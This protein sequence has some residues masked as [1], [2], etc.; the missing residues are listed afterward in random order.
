MPFASY[1]RFALASTDNTRVL[2][3]GFIM[4]FASSVGQTYFIGVFGPAIQDE[5]GLSHTA[6]GSIYMAGT[7]LS[8]LLLPWTGQQ[9]DRITLRRYTM[10]VC[11][12]L[13]AAAAF[14][15]LVPSAVFLIVAILLLRQAGQGLAIHTGTTAVAR[16][17][18]ADRG[19]AIAFATLG[20]SAGGSLLPFLAVLT[21]AAVGWRITFAA[22]AAVL[23]LVVTPLAWWL[24]GRRQEDLSPHETS[25][26]E[27][28]TVRASES[29]WTRAQVLRDWRFYFVVP[30]MVAPSIIVT[31]LFFHHPELARAKEWGIDWVAGSYWIYAAGSVAASLTA[32]PLIDR[33][34]A[35]QILPGSLI[36]M[37][38]ALFIVWAFDH[39]LWA[40][41]YLLL[42]GLTVGVNFT[43]LTSLWAEVYGVRHFGAIRSLATSISVFSSALGPLAMG[44]P[45]DAGVSVGNICALMALYC[46]AATVSL[47]I[48]LR[49]YDRDGAVSNAG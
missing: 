45:M 49:G 2:A 7:L 21:I 31:A 18:R 46:L 33:L 44:A 9:I 24:L 16:G 38:L 26:T 28:A 12:G 32:G 14:M 41:P 27:S 40:L 47:V 11:A 13:V 48:A 25:T 39:Y 35:A 23:A 5:F 4:A 43:A 8:A 22:S 10:L 19:K 15:A 3:F 1:L 37:L 20:F 6:W 29:S 17:F 36:S 34:S 30:A 42:L